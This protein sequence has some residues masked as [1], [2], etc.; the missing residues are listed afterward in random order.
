MARRRDR[1]QLARA[2]RDPEHE[3]LPVGEPAGLLA[4]AQRREHDRR[5]ASSAAAIAV[6]EAARARD[7][8]V[9]G[10][11]DVVVLGCLGVLRHGRE[12]STA[13]GL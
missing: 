11:G 1:Q 10:I 4:D 3:R 8:R 12:L 7:Q 5:A 6:D 2:L 13:V 9:A